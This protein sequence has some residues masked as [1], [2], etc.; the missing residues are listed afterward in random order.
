MV[1]N[2]T[3]AHND[4]CRQQPAGIQLL[5][6]I[7]EGTSFSCMVMASSPCVALTVCT[8]A[9]TQLQHVFVFTCACRSPYDLARNERLWAYG[10][11][12]TLEQALDNVNVDDFGKAEAVAAMADAAERQRT[13]KLLGL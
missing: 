12:A 8:V 13:T 2:A 10:A 9:A 5:L 6:L 4:A 7:Q 3:T 1:C 11:Y